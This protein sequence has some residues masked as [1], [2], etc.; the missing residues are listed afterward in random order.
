M[1][2]TVCMWCG[3]GWP[4]SADEPGC[5]EIEAEGQYATVPCR[6]PEEYA[7]YAERER[8]EQARAVLWQQVLREEKGYDARNR[9]YVELLREHG[10][11]RERRPGDP[12]T[13]PCGR[14]I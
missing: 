11:I 2:E 3:D 8:R 4:M 6:R 1:S 13:L 14:K 5:H 9:R 7:K 12:E 10:L